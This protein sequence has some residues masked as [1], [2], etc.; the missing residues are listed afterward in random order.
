[1][2]IGLMIEHRVLVYITMLIKQNMKDNGMKTN[3]MD[4]ELK[5]GL[6]EL[7]IQAVIE[8][9]KKK[10]KVSLDGVMVLNIMANLQIIT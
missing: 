9:V 8:M 10:D 6:M 5:H 1:M 7:C 3:N 4:K 2:V